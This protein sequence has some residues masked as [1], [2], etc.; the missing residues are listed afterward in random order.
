MSEIAIIPLGISPYLTSF[1]RFCQIRGYCRGGLY[2]GFWLHRGTWQAHI[3]DTD[4]FKLLFG[5]V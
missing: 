4:Y 2:Q 3:P 5:F 1:R